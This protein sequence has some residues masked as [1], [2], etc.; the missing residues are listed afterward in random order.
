MRSRA[1]EVPVPW[2]K[3]VSPGLPLAGPSWRCDQSARGGGA[4]RVLGGTERSGAGQATNF[5]RGSP[6]T[7]G[8]V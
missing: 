6:R 4:M 7:G 1:C 5:G 8:W 2:A 3:V